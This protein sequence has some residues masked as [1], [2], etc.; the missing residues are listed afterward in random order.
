MLSRAMVICYFLNRI[1][2]R[3]V[4]PNLLIRILAIDFKKEL[5]LRPLY[6]IQNDNDFSSKLQ[7]NNEWNKK[8]MKQK[9]IKFQKRIFH[10]SE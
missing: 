3:K 9:E 10:F 8:S 1:L 6:D 5:D 2:K 4:L 7:I